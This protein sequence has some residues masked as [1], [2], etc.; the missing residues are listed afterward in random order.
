MEPENNIE[1]I[2]KGYVDSGAQNPLLIVGNYKNAFGS[3]LH[4]Q[5]SNNRTIRWMGAIYNMQHLNSLRH[6][7]LMYF[8][9]HTVGGTNPSLLEAMACKTF[10]VSH[11]NEFNEAILGDDALYFSD[12]LDISRIVRETKQKNMTFIENNF[13]KINQLYTPDSITTRYESLFKS[14]LTPN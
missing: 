9:G 13:N 8:H 10:I 1:T 2:I 7:C 11:R 6:H 4:K 12:S 5:Y 3:R 14:C